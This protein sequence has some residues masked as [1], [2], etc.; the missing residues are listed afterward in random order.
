MTGLRGGALACVAIV[1]LPFALLSGASAEEHQWQTTTRG[2][3][4]M[5]AAA[6]PS[7][8]ERTYGFSTFGQQAASVPL[9]FG[10]LFAAITYIGI[11]NWN[12][13][14][15]SFRFHPEHWFGRSTG[16]GGTDKLG[17]FYTTYVMSDLLFHAIRR[18]S[19]LQDGAELTAATLAVGLMFYVEI[20]DG[21]SGDHGFSRED[22]TMDLLGA[23][24]S[25]LRNSVPG[26]RETLDFRMEYQPSGY[27]GFD[28]LADYAG[29]K[30][31]FA[32]K[33]AGFEAIR[34][35]PLRFVELHAGYYTRGF[36]RE[37]RAL[38]L[39]K[40]RNLYFG[41]GL[42][43]QELLFGAPAIKSHW[44]GQVGRSVLEYVQ[45]PYTSLDARHG[46]DGK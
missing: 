18:N 32:L 14:N 20:F 10:A 41:V 29:Q 22:M 21:Y 42:N 26:L 1:G 5:D 28:P 46:I 13:G 43:L 12:W 30:Y 11:K 19:Y 6:D 4:D 2:H 44:A 45:V 37:E 24:F 27:K 38:G 7:P 16:S 33:L 23:G 8:V 36:T 25:I 39:D 15:S 3:L 31:L 9:E 40:E 35:S 17:H 34:E